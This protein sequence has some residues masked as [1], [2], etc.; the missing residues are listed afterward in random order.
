MSDKLSSADHIPVGP[1][2]DD[3]EQHPVTGSPPPG[4]VGCAQRLETIG[5]AAAGISHHLNTL[6]AGIMGNLNLAMLDA[7]ESIR[8]H[9]EKADR[10]T[11]RAAAFTNRLLA[12][13][14]GAETATEPV[15]VGM[16]IDEVA[17]FM[18][19]VTDPRFPITVKK[20]C[21]LGAAITNSTA[22]HHALLTLCMNARDALYEAAESAPERGRYCIEIEAKRINGGAPLP[23][24]PDICWVVISVSD[25]GKGMT[26]EIRRQIFK[27]FFTTKRDRRGTGIGLATARDAIARHGG[28][29]EAAGAPDAGSIF[30]IYLP[31]ASPEEKI[32]SPS[33]PDE[34]PR[35]T[36]T[37]L[38]M[39]DNELVRGFG[40]A[41]LERQGYS[42]LLASDGNEG[43]NLF[44]RERAR[45]R[46]IIL[47]LIMPTFS[48]DEVLR[49]I[50]QSGSCP[51]V[52]LT[53]G[54]DPESVLGHLT[55]FDKYAFLM[56]PFSIRT[57]TEAVRKALDNKES[58]EL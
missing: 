28:R 41:I 51:R 6:L 25:S 58:Y 24:I 38:F 53:S 1:D 32:L 18:R 2:G 17:D 40:K 12:L 34:M 46:L 9:L 4:S 50:Q 52:I 10:A 19:D 55:E 47:D 37:I 21:S 5:M 42:V 16:I 14:R 44:F 13:V 56:K 23:S 36:E 29:I 11:V 57:L 8:P 20:R 3:P 7:P 26:D 39:D 22:L 48:G 30:T 31:A 43:L 49:R 15:D 33:L 35:G 27:P 54:Y 45:I